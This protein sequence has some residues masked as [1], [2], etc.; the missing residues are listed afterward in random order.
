MKRR[1]RILLLS[2]ALLGCMADARLATRQ[3]VSQASAESQQLHQILE[4]YFEEF[5]K[6]APLF[7][8]SIGDYRYNDQLGIVISE[9]QRDRRRALYQRYLSKIAT[10]S[11]DRLEANDQLV[12]AVLERT[13]TRNLEAL[14]FSQHLQPVRQLNSMAV[15]FPVIGSGN[16]VHPFKTVK[17]Y[18]D[19]L[20]RI[21]S[22]QVWV[23]TAIVNMRKGVELGIVQPRVV[24]ERTLPQLNAMI[25][26]E[27]EQSLFFRPIRRMPQNFS[28]SE[29]ARLTRAYKEAIE[30]RIVPSYRKL[31]SFVRDEY[32]PK[33]RLTF[34]LASLPNGNAWYAQ[35]VKTRTTTDLTPEQI[36]QMGMEEIRRIK[37]EM[38]RMRFASG[39]SGSLQEFSRHLA[40]NAP[41]GF[42]NRDDLIHGYEAIRNKVM[43][44]LTK[45]FGHLPK[46]KFEIRTV[47]EFREKSSP[48]QY[49]AASP[50]GTR[51]G[52]FYV[53]V[54]G[55]E[56]N[57][58]RPSESLFLH[59]TVPGHHFQISIQREQ[60]RLPRFRRFVNYSAFT[61]GWALY[62]E[63][64]GGELGL[65]NDPYQYFLRLNSELFRAV[66]LVVD[67]GLHRKNW[68]R[69]QALRFMM[70]H[71]GASES[72]AS[73]EID[74]YIA[75]PAQALSY[76]IGQLRISAI[77]AKAEQALG[78]KFDIRAFHDELLKDGAMP[79]DLLEVKMDA[80]IAKGIQ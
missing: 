73:L 21:D 69:D 25:V 78:P 34:G 6:L 48:S 57:A 2:L 36:F 62:A 43:P 35:F 18:D 7:A 13:L 17:D 8:T 26:G 55:I 45:L 67:V 51:P 39:F 20:K 56:V 70:D 58:R 19:F 50:D 77:R 1:I 59:E 68:S 27:P 79:L 40:K 22:F 29:K 9:E 5:L 12:L 65:Y 11:R 64:L 60:E 80:W 14:Q 63:S 54:S 38:E 75:W 10:I 23:D 46:A 15:D 53:N 42:T 72:G 76:K 28:E 71:T 49:Q 3:R 16:G 52:I 32:L 66:R 61:E 31:S 44:R 24:I 74:R 47:E 41:A 4:D 37:K 33:T 30:Q